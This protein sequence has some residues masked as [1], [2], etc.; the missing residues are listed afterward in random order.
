M[1]KNKLLVGIGFIILLI[2]WKNYIPESSIFGKY[3]NNN[4]EPILEGPSPIQ[5]GVDTLRLFENGTFKSRTW[6]NGTYEISRSFMRTD[7]DL[8]YTYSMGKAGFSTQIKKSMLGKNKIWLNYDL[9]FYFQK[10]E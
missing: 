2:A 5:N 10:T 3:V 4:T 7:I 9:G 6:G 8:T 1:K